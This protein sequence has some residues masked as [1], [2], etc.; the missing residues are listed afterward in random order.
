MQDRTLI[1]IKGQIMS[2]VIKFRAWDSRQSNEMIN[3]ETDDSCC[4]SVDCIG[5][6]YVDYQYQPI[7]EPELL[8]IGICKSHID[9]EGVMEYTGLKDSR[10]VEIYESDVVYLA[11]FGNYVC[12]F[13]TFIDLY[14]A[15]AEGDI[16]E[17]LGNVHENPELIA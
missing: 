1:K 6:A 10:G 2:R 5:V 3:K 9:Y 16:G 11:G 17:I 12:E 15:M 4:V 7:D 8:E 14:E 13:L